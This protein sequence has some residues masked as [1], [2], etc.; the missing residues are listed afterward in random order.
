MTTLF[1]FA[2]LVVSIWILYLAF[3]A[4]AG[5]YQQY[6]KT[7]KRLVAN[8]NRRYAIFLPAYKEDA[9]IVA[10]AKEAL[11]QNYATANFDVVVI[12]DSL[13][14][15]TLAE[16]RKLPIHTVEVSFENSTKSKALNAAMRYLETQVTH[17][18]YDIA[19]VLDA[20]NVL[21][22]QFLSKINA[23]FEAGC[24]VVQ[25]HRTAKNSETP[26]ALL[27]AISE[28]INNYI[29]RFGHRAVGLSAALIGSGMAFD[30]LLFKTV[31]ADV[32]AVG[33]FD[34][35]LEMRLLKQ[36]ITIEYAEDALC[37]DEKVKNPQV[38]ERQR[39]RWIAAQF[40]YLKLNFWFGLK[41]LL[42]GNFDY[43]DKVVQTMIPP[44]VLLLAA[45]FVLFLVAII[46]G[47]NKPLAIFQLL[48][49]CFTLFISIPFHLLIKLSWR[50]FLRLPELF[51]RFMKSIFKVY[52]A[53]KQFIHT[54]HGS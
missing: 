37:F 20:D 19:L 38:F 26:T 9:V 25:G 34:K 5:L 53:K 45:S 11:A 49:L 24:R 43:F 39:T 23:Y 12:A 40:K 32:E 28:E 10:S 47:H 8:Q 7:P 35:E 44:R 3:F 46:S 2:L 16:L 30:Y 41:A 18:Q 31:M 27:D 1:T 52:E 33:G 13:K 17:K 50:E 21:E 48:L 54:P 42:Q 14:E 51:W 15:E 22:P 6:F 36:K 4:M 29:F